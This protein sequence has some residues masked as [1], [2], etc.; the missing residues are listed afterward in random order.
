VV[1]AL[2]GLALGLGAT[3]GTAVALIPGLLLQGVGL[4]VVLTVNDPVGM[5]AVAEGDSGQA[6]GIINTAEQ[7]G[8][9]VGIAG[10]GALQ[11]SY[12]FH[13]LYAR[14][15][16]R[17]I[18]PTPA[19][20]NTVRDFIAKAEQRGLHNVPQ[21]PTVR[22]VFHVLVQS[23]AHSFQVAFYASAGVAL[24]GAVACAVLVRQQ[25]RTLDHPIFGRRSRWITA[26]AA[27]TPGLT[28]LPPEAL[29]H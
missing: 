2:S 22:S 9:A 7:L 25:P 27:V 11:L 20:F 8:G 29:E 19:Q 3:G 6:A 26:N 5:N 28:R 1:L 15:A 4:G 23:H 12:Y 17:G 10:L 16:S 21:N 14:L 18:R 13:V 24:A